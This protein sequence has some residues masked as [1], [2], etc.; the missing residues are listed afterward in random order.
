MPEEL[1]GISISE[2]HAALDRIA[3]SVPFARSKQLQRML[4]FIVEET[5]AGHGDML[6]EYAVGVEVFERPE[7]YDP[8]LDAIVRVEARRLRTALQRYYA[9][10][11]ATD[12]IAIE[13]TKG[14]YVPNFRRRA[15]D[16]LPGSAGE[17]SQVS[18]QND[19]TRLRVLPNRKRLAIMGGALMLLAAATALGVYWYVREP[20]SSLPSNAS[21]VILP[22][23][24]LSNDTENEFFC[25][26]LADQITT[27]LAKTGRLRVVA[28]TSAAMFKRGDDIRTIARNLKVN[29]VLEGSVRKSNGSLLVNAQLINAADNLHI[30]SE[31]YQRP[32]ADSIQVQEEI[33]EAITYG[34][35]NRLGAEGR[36]LTR[37][38]HYSANPEANALYWKGAFFR[39]PMGRA[40]WRNDLLKSAGYFE[41]AVQTDP[42]FALAYAALSDIY[43]SLAWERG[44]GK[45]T[46]SFMARARNAAARALELDDQLA[47]AH[48]ALGA[49]QF[50]SEYD[51]VA[52]ENSF[53]KALQADP[54]NGKARMWYAYALVMQKR[55]DEAI[56]QALEAKKLDPMSYMS[57]THLAVVYY[58]ARHYGDALKLV[59]ETIELSNTAPAHGLR[60]MILETQGKHA[61]AIKEYQ[62][63][64]RIVPNHPYIKGMLG[65]AL[66]LSGHRA[67]AIHLLNSAGLEYEQGGL[68]ELKSAYIY[69]AL[70]ERD[71]ALRQ[72][73]RDYEQRDPELPYI[74]ADPVFDPIRGDSRFISLLKKMG[75]HSP[76]S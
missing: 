13:L 43:V 22:F 11:G 71:S 9:E 68:S 70:G 12:Q 23:D 50:F 44:G 48:G 62:A 75:L 73:E 32:S 67:E 35:R 21:I 46:Q 61:E 33:A 66:A 56:Y 59:G 42:G 8:R 57:T 25:F 60:G 58:F 28:R 55:A 63:G 6:K 26:G 69:L 29:V 7:S 14:S 54:N 76:K 72:L 10:A 38:V 31:V 45:T 39:A 27:E 4:R 1:G 51:L 18:A 37:Q 5:L 30:W 2:I 52:A 65:H 49:V 64:L 74:N 3:A 19:G 40:N 20:I 16:A 36:D 34:I 53:H 24:N 15:S 41:Q 47:E 17:P